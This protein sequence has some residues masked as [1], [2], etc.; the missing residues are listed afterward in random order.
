MLMKRY[1]VLVALFLLVSPVLT[2]ETTVKDVV[3]KNPDCEVQGEPK[4][5][6]L[7]IDRKGTIKIRGVIEEYEIHPL[8]RKTVRPDI[9]K[10]GYFSAFDALL[11]V[12]GKNGIEIKY[13]FDKEMMTNVIDSLNGKPNW[14][15][16]AQY[17]GGRRR[18]EPA[19][20]MD[21]YPYKD[22]CE[23]EVYQVPKG[24]IKELYATFRNEVK[25]LEE[26]KGKVIVPEI[27]FRALKQRLTFDNVEVRS[28]GMRNDIFQ[29]G[30]ITGADIILS[31]AEDKKLSFNAEWV[32]KVGRS[33]VQ[34][35]YFTRFN[36]EET[37]G[38]AGFTYE[39]GDKR[40]SRRAKGFKGSGNNWFHMT[41][42]IRVIVSP[43]YMSW[44]RTD[45]PRGN[46]LRKHL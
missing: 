29:D 20:R 15:Y 5:T 11:Y 36:G 25:R 40:L 2:A 12:C 39:L 28:H 23:I 38:K 3:S 26:N 21:L 18:E 43:E 8:G 14:W 44:R 45:L 32:D 7:S 9:F 1:F 19:H 13:H 37:E 31:L 6:A 24:R 35:Y 33:L 41:S 27:T 42:D 10:K 22:R 4:N 30:V 46:I 34:S 16:A 17:D